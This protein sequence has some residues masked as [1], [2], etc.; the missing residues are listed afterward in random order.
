RAAQHK[1]VCGAGTRT[2][3]QQQQHCCARR[4]SP[5]RAVQLPEENHQHNTITARGAAQAARG[6]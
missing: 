6:A 1:L 3:Q 5:M 2:I 4:K